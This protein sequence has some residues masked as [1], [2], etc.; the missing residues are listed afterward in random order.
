[1]LIQVWSLPFGPDLLRIIY[2]SSPS[3]P[4]PRL[5]IRLGIV[6]SAQHGATL[7]IPCLLCDC[8]S[9]ITKMIPLHRFLLPRPVV[10]S[11]SNIVRARVYLNK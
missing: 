3:F 10:G 2:L 8:F 6:H 1:M 9:A 4:I 7:L 5:I 11:E